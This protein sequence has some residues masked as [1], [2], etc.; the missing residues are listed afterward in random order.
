MSEYCSLIFFKLVGSTVTSMRKLRHREVNCQ[1]EVT[2]TVSY[3]GK[4]YTQPAAWLWS[5]ELLQETLP[6]N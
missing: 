1:S 5:L 2:P 4:T 3:T 6:L